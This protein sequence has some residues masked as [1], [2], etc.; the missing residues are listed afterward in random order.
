ME[1]EKK[2]GF[3]KISLCTLYK[4]ILNPYAVLDTKTDVKKNR[5]YHFSLDAH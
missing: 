5:S 2:K 3:P 1:E 4:G